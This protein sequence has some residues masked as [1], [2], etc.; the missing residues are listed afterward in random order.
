MKIINKNLKRFVL[1][2]VVLISFS[3]ANAQQKEVKKLDQQRYHQIIK[4][5]SN[6]TTSKK[7][8]YLAQR[9]LAFSFAQSELTDKAFDAYA[10]LL[11]KYPSQA[12]A[13][14]KLNYALVAR[15]MELYGLSDSLILL[16]KSTPEFQDKP[17]FDDLTA[18]FYAEN[19][20]KRS[21]YWADY[22]F[23]S[24][25]TIKPFPNASALGEYG[26]VR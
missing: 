11:D 8:D 12:D 14:D 18:D 3:V 21:D 10:E 15:K 16:V 4:E 26:V 9:A 5:N 22:D 20:E 1:I 25:Y 19:K 13:V 2:L 24:K 23:N 6:K 17:L 7:N